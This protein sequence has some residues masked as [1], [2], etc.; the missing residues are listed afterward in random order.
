MTLLITLYSD[1]YISKITIKEKL[2]KYN[3][4]NGSK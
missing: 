4:A 3:P 1:F 2:K